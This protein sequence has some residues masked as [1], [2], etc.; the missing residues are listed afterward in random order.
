VPAKPLLQSTDESVGVGPGHRIVLRCKSATIEEAVGTQREFERL[1]H[2]TGLVY[3]VLFSFKGYQY[4]ILEGAKKDVRYVRSIL[5]ADP[6]QR[7]AEL[8]RDVPVDAC[9]TAACVSIPE[10]DHTPSLEYA[11][12]LLHSAVPEK[13][14][15]G[16]HYVRRALRETGIGIDHDDG[17]DR[18]QPDR[19]NDSLQWPGSSDGHAQR[20]IFRLL[21]PIAIA[22]ATSDIFLSIL[23]RAE[24]ASPFTP[25]VQVNLV[26]VSLLIASAL[27]FYKLGFQW[28][29]AAFYGSVVFAFTGHALWV[30]YGLSTPGL[31]FLGLM[32][33]QESFGPK[34]GNQ[35]GWLTLAAL[36]SLGLIGAAI[37]TGAL[38]PQEVPVPHQLVVIFALFLGCF[39]LGKSALKARTLMLEKNIHVAV[40]QMAL[41][42]RLRKAL[43]ARNRFFSAI[44]HEIRTPL[45]G[46][47]T[48]M[49]LIAHPRASA[50]AKQRYMVSVGKSVDNLTTIIDDVLDISRLET[51]GFRLESQRFDMR[52]LC[53]EVIEFFQ[54]VAEQHRN[55]LSLVLRF[56]GPGFVMGDQLRLKQMMSNYLSNAIK[57]T[58][59]GS[60]TLEVDRLAQSDGKSQWHFTVSDNGNGID[61]VSL[62]TLFKPFVQADNKAM[63]AQSGSGLGLSIVAGLAKQMQGRVGARSEPGRGSSFWFTVILDDCPSAT[64]PN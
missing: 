12:G 8:L 25:M 48:A 51:G 41:S 61:P 4:Q 21:P 31:S 56:E 57:F 28:G 5:Y 49:S 7:K 40:D 47:K 30:G 27:V 17:A 42:E 2:A 34:E 62:P 44:S 64:S 43:D 9:G 23:T 10:S 39:L 58:D 52:I 38:V 63:V 36:F 11:F 26:F 55:G 33:I 3:C 54:P 6:C 24:N 16:A 29:K 59:N 14:D 35:I 13:V 1:C 20:H 53:S 45:M 19:V 46:I 32:I 18:L 37:A 15:A 60:V 50:E 22:G